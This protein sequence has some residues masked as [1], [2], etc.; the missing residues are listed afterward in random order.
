[1]TTATKTK[2]TASGELRK[3][4]QK[5][6]RAYAPLQ[7]VKRA[8]EAWDAETERLRGEYTQDRHIHPEQYQGS[9]FTP[10]PGHR[11]R[12]T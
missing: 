8:R 3:L 11:S 12:E 9:T 7:D 5:R 6:E 1:V 2:P 10:K 4:E